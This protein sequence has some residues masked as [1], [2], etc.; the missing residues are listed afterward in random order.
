MPVYRIAKKINIKGIVQGVG[1]RPFIFQLAGRHHLTGWISNTSSGV[2]IHIEGAAPDIETFLQ[3]VETAA[4]PLSRIT[5]I[6]ATPCPASGFQQFSIS[7][8]QTETHATALISPDVSICAD[9]RKELFDPRDRRFHYPF[10][11]CTNC[12]PRYT[13]IHAIPYDRPN[14]SMKAFTMCRVCQAEYD[15]PNNRRFH[16]QPNACPVCG[17]QVLL[18]DADGKQTAVSDPIQEAAKHLQN[19]QI[20][21]VKGL[22]GFHLAVDATNN[23][24]VERLRQ[25]KHREEKPFALMAMDVPTIRSFARMD[26][27]EEKMLTS[28]VR[29]ILLLQKRPKSPIVESVSPGNPTVGV[30]LPYTPLH[31]LLLS[32]GFKALVMTSG[33]LSDEPICI[34]NAEAFKRLKNIADCFL[35]HDRDI[36]IR[37]DDSIARRISGVTRLVRRSRGYVPVPVFL[38]HRL[39]PI[40]ACGA[41]MKNTVCLTRDDRAF[42][43]QHIGDLEHPAA[44]DFFDETIT[45][46]KALLDIRPEIIAHDL[47]PDY[48]STR[49]ALALHDAVRIPVQHHHAH[50][51]SCMAENRMDGE[52]IGLAFDGTG[53]GTDNTIWGGEALLADFG[54]F[55]RLAHLETVPMPGAAFAIREPWRMALGYLHTAFG[56]DL[57]NMD[58][59]LITSLPPDAVRTLIRMIRQKINS[60]LTSSLGRLFD[61]VAAIMG[62]RNRVSFEGQ[63]A[64]ELE[65]L[66]GTHPIDM[67]KE[68]VYAFEWSSGATRRIAIRPLVS[69]IVG[70]MKSG[71]PLPL[72]SRR[73]HATL[74]R[75]FA[76]LC[77]EL[78]GETGV[79]RIVLSGG[80]FQN[81]LLLEGLISI[82]EQEGFAVFSHSLV[83]TNDGGISLG[84]AVIAA[85]VSE[86]L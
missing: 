71:I 13:I 63:A 15:D 28:S 57:A 29:P 5:D 16:A 39:P 42:V 72:I 6:T 38:N 76:S 66:A 58:I 24:A 68:T 7:E 77:R 48:F 27:D 49:Y 40:L 54:G 32:H 82:L 17:P 60:P 52:V 20:L 73:F 2:S 31:Y 75:L 53:L 55:K 62:I 59:P 47:H 74:I 36:L 26:A 3:A 81:A 30:M 86:H 1:F 14:T 21:A 85:T 46:L 84:Q 80:C 67:R 78:K 35:M 10:I 44:H 70:D 25:K 19:G 69:G 64:M 22:G 9:C 79:N 4:P 37:S 11:N 51:A 12:G 41:E 45:H 50:I 34:D 8:S 65:M 33:N 43:S 83:P 56:D 61:G 23:S 18:Y